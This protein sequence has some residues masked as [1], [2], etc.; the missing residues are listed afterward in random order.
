MNHDPLDP[1]ITRSDAVAEPEPRSPTRRTLL[2]LLAAV[3]I[4]PA[5]TPGSTGTSGTDADPLFR[6][7]GQFEAITAA[8]ERALA[9]ID[10]LEARLVAEVGYPRVRLPSS[11][12]QSARYAADPWSIDRAMLPRRHARRLKRQLRRRQH[13]Y[14]ATALDLGLTDAIRHEEQVAGAVR[15]IGAVLLATPATNPRAVSLKLLVLLA[16]HQPGPAFADAP[17]WWELR[18]ILADVTRLAVDRHNP[19]I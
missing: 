7:F 15:A 11:P 4:L 17:P 2:T 18:L 10:R 19:S 12:G 14:N 6:L 16:L 1:N 5:G 3:P 13:T 8:H 9:R